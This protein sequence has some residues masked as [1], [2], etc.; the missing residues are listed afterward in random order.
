MWVNL[1]VFMF[2]CVLG[3]FLNI[4]YYIIVYI[5]FS[6]FVIVKVIF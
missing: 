4:V 3:V 5:M 1:V 2:L 6:V